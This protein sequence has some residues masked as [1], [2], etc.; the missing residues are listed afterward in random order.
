MPLRASQ[1]RVVRVK[2]YYKT[3]AKSPK[4]RTGCGERWVGLDGLR[5]VCYWHVDEKCLC[6]C[7][8]TRE[9]PRE[10]KEVA[11]AVDTL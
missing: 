2:T 1:L 7:R 4:K 5:H 9:T 10:E 8:A 11:A 3:L 6:P